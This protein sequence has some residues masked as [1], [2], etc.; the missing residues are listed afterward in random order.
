MNVSKDS[1]TMKIEAS[2]FINLPPEEVWKLIGD[3]SSWPRWAPVYLQL[4]QTSPGPL[5]QGTTF[6]SKHP[7]NRTLDEKVVAYE[8][9]Q[10]FAFEFT[11][12]PIKGSRETYTIEQSSE[13]GKASSKL[14]REFDLRFSG[15]FK[16]LG[17]FLVAPGFRKESHVEVDNVKRLLEKPDSAGNSAP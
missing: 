5:G 10:R 2:S 8:P 12:G 14:T 3:T 4:T 7:Q 6:H 9:N 13:G 17:P 11:S 1:A 15:V 16:L